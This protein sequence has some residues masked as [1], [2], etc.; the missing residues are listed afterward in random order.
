MPEL[1]AW[2]VT[3]YTGG[4]T[5]WGWSVEKGEASQGSLCLKTTKRKKGHRQSSLRGDS[6]VMGARKYG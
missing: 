4:A 5:A 3:E 1:L 6:R 2:G